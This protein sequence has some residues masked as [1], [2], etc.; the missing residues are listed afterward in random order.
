MK[1]FPFYR[2]LDEMDCGPTCLKMIAAYYGKVYSTEYLKELS[3]TSREGVSLLG[4]S[5]AAEAISMKS[6]AVKVDF[7]T[8]QK[9]V[10]LPCII[11]WQQNHFVVVYRIEKNKVFVADPSFNVIT[12]SRD[13]FLA[14]WLLNK[15]QSTTEEDRKSTRLNSSHANISYA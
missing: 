6:F 3:H 2:Q 4:L 1:R 7:A 10:T 5:E 14:G 8:L 13:E 15:K 12:Y 11:H 9:E